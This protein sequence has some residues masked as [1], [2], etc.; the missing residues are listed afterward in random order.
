MSSLGLPHTCLVWRVSCS[1]GHITG[2]GQFLIDA[3]EPLTPLELRLHREGRYPTAAAK[4]I[5]RALERAR[6]EQQ[7]HTDD[8]LDWYIRTNASWDESDH[9]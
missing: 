7:H 9:Q 1:F 5:D 2:L 3:V 8:V 6:T 4:C